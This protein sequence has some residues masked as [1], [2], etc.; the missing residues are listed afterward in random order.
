M[1]SKLFIK[2]DKKIVPKNNKHTMCIV[3]VIK[4]C[5]HQR[6]WKLAVSIK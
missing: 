1:I 3:I 2:V 6:T 4:S 5:H